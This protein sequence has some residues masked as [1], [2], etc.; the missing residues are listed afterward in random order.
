MR[1]LRHVTLALLAT[2]AL[3]FAGC[4][5]LR[6]SS[7]TVS[8]GRGTLAFRTPA[9]GQVLVDDLSWHTEIYM[10]AVPADALVEVD[11]YTQQVRVN[12]EV[13]ARLRTGVAD[14]Y[15]IA[16]VA[17]EPAPAAAPA[18]ATA[19]AS[20]PATQAAREPA[21]EPASEPAAT[22]DQ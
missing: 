15:R 8:E 20:E 18:P 17:A 22:P 2:A 10:H 3:A 13:V 12:G 5:A 11:P 4:S 6:D 9:A 16:F 21:S 1:R 14:E 7:H 19:A